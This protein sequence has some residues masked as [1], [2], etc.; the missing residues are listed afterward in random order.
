MSNIEKFFAFIICIFIIS[1]LYFGIGVFVRKA[2]VLIKETPEYVYYKKFGIYNRNQKI[3]KYHKPIIY[4]GKVTKRTQ[5]VVRN[6][7]KYQ[8]YPFSFNGW[9]FEYRT[10]VSYNNS[11]K[12]V[13]SGM[14]YYNKYKE[15]DT[16]KVKVSFYPYKQ[17][18]ILN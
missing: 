12:H 3:Y 17:V 14:Y 7:N 13:L 15:G 1:A 11:K 16:V 4:N 5:F 6:L 8:F 18:E 2:P 10:Y 9:H